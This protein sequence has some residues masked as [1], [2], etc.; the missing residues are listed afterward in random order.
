MAELVWSAPFEE[1]EVGQGFRG[2]SRIVGEEDVLGFCALTGDWHPQHSD[3]AWAARSAFGERIAHGMLVLSLAIGLVPLDP[4]RVKALRRI[5]DAVFKR[6]LRF[7]ERMS[8]DGEISSLRRIDERAGLV[9]LR[10]GIRNGENALVC[11]A[12]VQVLW[13]GGGAE[14]DG[15]SRGGG[16][17]PPDGATADEPAHPD[18]AAADEPARPDSGAAE[19]PTPGYWADAVPGIDDRGV[20]TPLPF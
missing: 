12:G 14:S 4:L 1:L 20:P 9:D 10:L 13:L 11:R 18:S 17:A 8:V 5:G 15:R 19:E 7:G 2:A 16:T 6:P 3:G